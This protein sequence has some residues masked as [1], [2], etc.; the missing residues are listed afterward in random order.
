MEELKREERGRRE[1]E[2]LK[3]EDRRGVKEWEIYYK[4]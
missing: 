2:E 3:R 4:L 1:V